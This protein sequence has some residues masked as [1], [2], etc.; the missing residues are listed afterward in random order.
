[1]EEE[2]QQVEVLLQEQLE[3]HL[4][5]HQLLHVVVEVVELE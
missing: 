2:V 5:F 4:Q 1:L 3:V